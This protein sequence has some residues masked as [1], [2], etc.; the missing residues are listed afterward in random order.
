M[1]KAFRKMIAKAKKL[2]KDRISGVK[3]FEGLLKTLK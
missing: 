2:M 1:K 3:E